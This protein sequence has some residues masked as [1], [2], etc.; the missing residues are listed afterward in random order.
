M[1]ITDSWL[2]ANN[3]RTREVREEKTDRDGL[4]VRATPNGKLVFQMRYRYNGKAKRLDIGTYPF[5]SLKEARKENQRLKG[6]LEKGHDPKNIRFL[7]KQANMEVET[8]E[9][10]FRQW[11]EKYCKKNKKHHFE[12]LRTYELYVFPKLGKLPADKITL[13]T[14]INLLEDLAEKL[15]TTTIR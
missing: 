11:Y 14:W 10:F 8:F 7:E 2:R 5:I 3:G 9:E 12:I 6:Q 4:S 13:H 15:P 1:A